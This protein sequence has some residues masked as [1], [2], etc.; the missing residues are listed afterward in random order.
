VGSE[1]VRH[2][3]G[4]STSVSFLSSPVNGVFSNYSF[5]RVGVD[6][7][8]IDG[9]SV[10]AAVGVFSVSTSSKVEGGGMTQEQ[11][12]PTLSGFV[13]APRVGYGYMFIDM[14]G[15][16]P[17]LGITYVKAGSSFESP[18]TNARGESSSNRLA[19]SLDV[20][21]VI[22]PAT[23]AVITIAPTLDLGLSGGNKSSQTVGGVTMEQEEDAKATDIGLQAGL[24]IAF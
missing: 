11:D 3:A 21:L 20:P 22:V 7:F 16:W 10:G 13:L 9:L 12:G 6:F 5:A 18:V 15:I 2:G 24:A 4:K 23:H 8:P 14:V 19:L 17:R 1:V